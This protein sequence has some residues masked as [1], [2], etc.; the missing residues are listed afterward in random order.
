M[1]ICFEMTKVANAS[2]EQENGEAKVKNF[3]AD[4]G[5]F[6]VAAETTR[7]AMVFTDISKYVRKIADI[8]YRRVSVFLVY[9]S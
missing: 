2:D 9:I 8:P 6:V 4:L 5:P 7:M 3:E 1:Q